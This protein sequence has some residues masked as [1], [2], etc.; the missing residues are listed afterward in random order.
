MVLRSCVVK[1]IMLFPSDSS[2]HRSRAIAEKKRWSGDQRQQEE[3]G[4]AGTGLGIALDIGS[5][6]DFLP[7]ATR[8]VSPGKQHVVLVCPALKSTNTID[9]RVIRERLSR[10]GLKRSATSEP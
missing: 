5:S 9:Y 2:G 3:R 8:A 1:K 4:R 10:A 7:T 6:F